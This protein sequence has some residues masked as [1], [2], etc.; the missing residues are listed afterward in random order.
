MGQDEMV[1]PRFQIGSL[2]E[3]VS[4]DLVIGC[5]AD[6]EN[7]PNTKFVNPPKGAY[8]IYLGCGEKNIV[9]DDQMNPELSFENTCVYHRF[10]FGEQKIDIIEGSLDIDLAFKPVQTNEV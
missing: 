3:V 1:I 10:L 8:L 2:L 4:D 9:T 5:L 6:D 7:F